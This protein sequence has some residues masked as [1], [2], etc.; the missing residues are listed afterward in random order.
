MQVQHRCVDLSALFAAVDR[1]DG[2]T[3]VDGSGK[4]GGSRSSLAID[5]GDG[6]D[7]DDG[8]VGSVNC[9]GKEGEVSFETPSTAD[10]SS[11]SSS[12]RREALCERLRGARPGLS[13]ISASEDGSLLHFGDISIDMSKVSV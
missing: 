12:S 2:R 5:G 11:S 6:G 13:S 4:N 3:E 9:S 7:G 8:N 10:L 1:R